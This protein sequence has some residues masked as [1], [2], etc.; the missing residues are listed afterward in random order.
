MLIALGVVVAVFTVVLAIDALT[1]RVQATSC[2]SIAD[3]RRDLRMQDAFAEPNTSR[4]LSGSES[5][6]N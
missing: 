6:S 2:C 1:G 4:P 3:P 5:A